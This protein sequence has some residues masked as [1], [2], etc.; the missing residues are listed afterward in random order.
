MSSVEPRIDLFFLSSFFR[1][2]IFCFYLFLRDLSVLPCRV[3]V[4][5][6]TG[7]VQN[8]VAVILIL[9]SNPVNPMNRSLS[10]TIYLF[11]HNFIHPFKHSILLPGLFTQIQRSGVKCGGILSKAK[12]PKLLFVIAQRPHTKLNTAQSSHSHDVISANADPHLQMT[13]IL[14]IIPPAFNFYYA[15]CFSISCT[16]PSLNFSPLISIARI[17][18]ISFLATATIAIFLRPSCPQ[19]TLS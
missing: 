8:S 17:I 10:R 15:A 11:F 18:L 6:K 12:L 3:V 14:W 2:S 16:S 13:G 9:L 7:V 1:G 19:Q 5:A 4:L